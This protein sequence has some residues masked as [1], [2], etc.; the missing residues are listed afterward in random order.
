MLEHL[1]GDA[2]ELHEDLT[3]GQ[4]S[5][6]QQWGIATRIANGAE[7]DSG[8]YYVLDENKPGTPVLRMSERSRGLAQYFRYV[9]IGA[10]RLDAQSSDDA[11]KPTAFRNA[12]GTFVV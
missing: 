10:T 6:W 9:R 4:V 11:V 1:T 12:D 5:A 2:A 3:K 8:H 7:D